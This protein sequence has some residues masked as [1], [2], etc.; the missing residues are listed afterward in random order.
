MNYLAAGKIG[1]P[2]GLKGEAKFQS[3]SGS[4]AHLK[5]LKNG[6]LRRSNVIWKNDIEYIRGAAPRYIIK[7]ADIDSPETVNKLRGAE[8]WIPREEAAALKKDEYFIADLVGCTLVHDGISH[9]TVISV[10]DNGQSNYLEVRD[11]K[12]KIY[13]VPFINDFVGIVDLEGKTIEFIAPWLH[14]EE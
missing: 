11:E 10:W 1:P 13:N 5:S 6:E 14:E 4:I 7:F 3:Y 12:A 2:H 8:L 9:G